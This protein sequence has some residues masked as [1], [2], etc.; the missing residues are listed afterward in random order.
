[1]LHFVTPHIKF[2]P[3]THTEQLQKKDTNES[4][5]PNDTMQNTP[6]EIRNKNKCQKN[7]RR[8]FHIVHDTTCLPHK[9]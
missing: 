4:R 6:K 5:L 7:V 9:I 1:M 3:H 2:F 8:L